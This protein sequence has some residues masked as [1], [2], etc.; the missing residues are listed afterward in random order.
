MGIKVTGLGYM[1]CTYSQ[2]DHIILPKNLG[3]KS[4][5]SSVRQAQVNA[6]KMPVKSQVLMLTKMKITLFLPS[7]S[8]SFERREKNRK[9]PLN[10]LN[11]CR[12]VLIQ[13][14]NLATFHGERKATEPNYEQLVKSWSS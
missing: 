5:C 9:C 8:F 11:A 7:R 6:Y 13:P 4:F 12:K 1:K 10:V 2:L 14:L 3:G